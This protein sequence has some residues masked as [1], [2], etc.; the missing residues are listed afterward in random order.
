MDECMSLFINKRV[1]YGLEEKLHALRNLET[2]N[3]EEKKEIKELVIT[4]KHVKKF[5]KHHNKEAIHL[6]NILYRKNLK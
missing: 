5:I 3:A 4:I 6:A 1:L 2:K